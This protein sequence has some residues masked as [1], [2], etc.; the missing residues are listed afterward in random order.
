MTSEPIVLR[1]GFVFRRWLFLWFSACLLS[2]VQTSPLS[3]GPWGPT[4]PA[5][6]EGAT[7]LVP[8]PGDGSKVRITVL[9]ER[10]VRVERSAEDAFEDRKTVA[11]VNRKLDVP[12]F[13]TN[14]SDGIFSVQTE[15]LTLKYTIGQAFSADSFK[16]TG[17]MH[18]RSGTGKGDIWHYKYGQDDPHNLMGTIR[19]LD[20]KDNATLN[21]SQTENPGQVSGRSI[22][23]K[24]S[25]KKLMTNPEVLDTLNRLELN[26]SPVWGLS[27]AERQLVELAR[28]KVNEC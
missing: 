10:L 9:T 17:A 28:D 21:C 22:E 5:A 20:Q 27:M 13:S 3:G 16:V 14:Q 26:G 6:A 23:L 12:C 24:N 1:S 2:S 19:T 11:V 15:C 7:V 4:N 18:C 25:I 8:G